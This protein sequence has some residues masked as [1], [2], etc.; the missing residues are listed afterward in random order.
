MARITKND[1]YK[2][3]SESTVKILNEIGETDRG[4]EKLAKLAARKS[5]NGDVGYFDVADYAKQ[6]RKGDL[7]K[8]DLYA[9]TFNKEKEQLMCKEDVEK[10]L[11]KRRL[12]KGKKINE[13]KSPYMINEDE[14]RLTLEM[15]IKKT[16]DDGDFDC[17]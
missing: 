3:I 1:I 5:V 12:K 17:L 13:G 16:L 8:Q 4:Q 11:L 9:K 15:A 6:K 14:L 7:K 10:E 2:I